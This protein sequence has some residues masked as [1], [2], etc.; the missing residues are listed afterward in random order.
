MLKIDLLSSTEG[1]ILVEQAE[2]SCL[3][4]M[5]VAPPMCQICKYP[6]LRLFQILSYF[7][8]RLHSPSWNIR[9]LSQNT[10][11]R[12]LF[13]SIYYNRHGDILNV[14]P[15]LLTSGDVLL[16]FLPYIQVSPHHNK[17]V[18]L[19]TNLEHQAISSQYGAAMD[20]SLANRLPFPMRRLYFP[21]SS[22]E[23]QLHHYPPPHRDIVIAS[24]ISAFLMAVLIIFE[25]MDVGNG[26]RRREIRKRNM[27]VSQC[28]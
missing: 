12:H 10:N 13:Q 19:S 24:S 1:K 22:P 26:G 23:E 25:F 15:D 17:K 28:G 14:D 21:I 5:W 18:S 7:H 4:K 2:L 9:G 16:I 27:G 3:N 11:S 8:P 20:P 6:R